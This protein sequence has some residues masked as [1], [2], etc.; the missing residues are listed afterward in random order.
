MQ[1]ALAPR[2]SARS[3]ASICRRADDGRQLLHALQAD[4][5]GD[6]P[7][8]GVRWSRRSRRRVPSCV[9]GGR[10]RPGPLVPRAGPP[11]R[12]AAR[13][14]PPPP[15]RRPDA[16][17]ARRHRDVPG[18]RDVRAAH[19]RHVRRRRATLRSDGGTEPAGPPRR[20]RAAPDQPGPRRA[21]RAARPRLGTDHRVAARRLRRSRRRCAGGSASTTTTSP[22]SRS[23]STGTGIRWG[24]DAAHRRP[25]QLDALD[26][27]T[28]RAGLD[29]L[30]L[31]V[32]MTED[33]LPLVGGV[34]PLDDVDSG[35]IEP[36]R[37]RSPSS[38]IGC[39]S[40]STTGTSP[41][42]AGWADV[43]HCRRRCAD[44]R[45]GRATRGSGPS[46]IACWCDVVEESAAAPGVE[47]GLAELRALLA[48][49]LRG[50]PGRANFR[51][52]PSRS[53]RSCRCARCPTGSSACS[54]S[55]TARSRA[56][57][58][59]TATTSSS[60]LPQVGDHDVRSEDRQLLLDALLAAGDH[61]VV[62][63]SGRDERTNAPAAAVGADRRAARR[64]RRHRARPTMARPA[65]HVLVEH[66]LQ[67][68]DGRNFERQDRVRRV[69]SFDARRSTA[70]GP[71]AGL[72]ALADPRS[73]TLD[74]R[75]LTTRSSSSTTSC[76][77]SS[78]RPRRS[79]ASGSASASASGRRA[80]RRDPDRARR[81]RAVGRRRPPARTPA[82]RGADWTT[83][84]TPSGRAACCHRAPRRADP[85]RGAADVDAIHE[86]RW[87]EVDLTTR[88]RSVDVRVDS[89]RGRRVVGTVAGVYGDILVNVDVLPGGRQAPDR[90]VG[91]AA[92]ARRR[93]GAAG[94]TRGHRSD[95]RAGEGAGVARIPPSTRRRRRRTSAR[96]S[97]STAGAC[98]SRCRSTATPRRRW[99][100]DDGARASGRR[101]AAS[102]RR[103][104]IRDARLRARRRRAV[105]PAARRAHR[106]GRGRAR[107]G[108][109]RADPDRPLR[110]PAV[111]RPARVEERVGAVTA[112]SPFDV[113]GPL[114]SGITLLEASAGTGKTF[115]IAALAARYVAEGTPLDRM[116]LVTFG[117][118][119]TGELRARVRERLVT[120]E[121][122]LHGRR[123]RRRA[124]RRR[125][126]ARA[127]R[128]RRPPTNWS[129]DTARVA[130]ALA[131]F[132]A[133]TIATT[134]GFC[135]QVLSGIGVAGDV[136]RDVTFVEDLVRPRRRGRRR[137]VP[138]Q[139]LPPGT[140]RRSFPSPWPA[141]I[142][143]TVVGQPVG[144]DRPRRLDGP[145]RGDP[146]PA[147]R[148]GAR[149]GRAAQ[150]T[151]CGSSPTTTC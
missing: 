93:S 106:A 128:R 14:D 34:L 57:A 85:R 67:P 81:P 73:S 107:L 37:A 88:R 101:P 142:G 141:Q 21:R 7:P 148:A 60:G 32:A 2:A 92:R 112:P 89:R 98:A 47:L 136:D 76:G 10:Q 38:S 113:C 3:R 100:A 28:W 61:L 140:A 52:G 129:A 27:N 84:P 82:R 42:D 41:D 123:P 91:A 116:L 23:G 33:D 43:A 66:P 102:T 51:T 19:P 109:R 149:R 6:R 119:A 40:W 74:C 120:A 117:R 130:A 105:R 22:G 4:V 59:P 125:R 143:R 146:I 55:T 75:P 96:S 16:R 31:G 11:G 144:R 58:R 5:R 108:G 87:R 115:T 56:T 104:A 53:A 29:R 69:W 147:G 94:R 46:S 9:A 39:G 137:P 133:A 138:P 20:P 151:A 70:H 111:G 132:D 49:R 127:A 150:A 24:L 13:R 118:M 97:T 134:H 78:T 71:S 36:R 25:F 131:D 135:Q 65:T 124:E 145:A 114:P 110:P 95:G 90:G 99:L 72:A 48:D 63:Y 15:R 54:A 122:G 80:R 83:A 35:D 64:H 18:H 26:A 8:P 121:A 103:T 12:G 62:T 30:L 50:R 86:R 44:R 77:S 1:L 68:F 79:S 126:G 45:A 17:A 139:V